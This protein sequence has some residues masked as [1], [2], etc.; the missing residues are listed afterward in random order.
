[1]ASDISGLVFENRESFREWLSCNAA[2][3]EG[4]WL[5]FGKSNK[6]KTLSANDALEEALCFG[7]IDGQIRSL[8]DTKYLKY[9]SR[10]RKNSVWSEKNKAIA[11]MLIE[12]GLM[13]EYGEAAVIEAKRNGSWD[14]ARPEAVSDEQI[15]VL[16][17]R[18]AGIEP[19]FT[20]FMNMSRSVKKTYTALYMSGKSEQTRLKTLGRITERLNKNLKP[21]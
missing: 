19:A 17:D 1:M 5:T 11:Q 18:L 7:W 15:G 12:K 10:R 3:S 8:D 2:G 4:V 9:F 14:A 6:L 20:N 16:E 21:M 13:T